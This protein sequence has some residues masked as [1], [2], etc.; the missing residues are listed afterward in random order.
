[1]TFTWIEKEQVIRKID[2]ASGCAHCWDLGKPQPKSSPCMLPSR[3]LPVS[4]DTFAC[5]PSSVYIM[6]RVEEMASGGSNKHLMGVGQPLAS[7]CAKSWRRVRVRVCGC[8]CVAGP[9]ASKH[10]RVRV[11][12]PGTKVTPLRG[13]VT[14][15]CIWVTLNGNTY[16]EQ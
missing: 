14:W 10:S 16:T 13:R 9:H 15:L 12:T 1:M 11:R 3:P 7:C 8:C 2:H 5:H 4:K 6:W